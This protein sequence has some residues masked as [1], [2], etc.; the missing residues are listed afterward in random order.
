MWEFCE[1]GSTCSGYVGPACFVGSVGL[2]NCVPSTGGWVGASMADP[3]PPNTTQK[4][5]VP[6]RATAPLSSIDL[7]DEAGDG[8]W[9]LT[10][11][12]GTPRG[13]RV[14]SGGFSSDFQEPPFLDQNKISTVVYA[15]QFSA[16][17]LRPGS[18]FQIAFGSVNHGAIV[19]ING[20]EV[21]AHFGPMMPFNIDVTDAL[22]SAAPGQPVNLTVS[23][24][25]YHRLIGLV[26]SG[27]MY[28]EAW[29]N[30]TDGWQSRSC[31]GICR[32]VRLI[33][34]P[35]LRV[36]D[37]QTA[38]SVGPPAT[39]NVRV[40]I[41][42]DALTTSP[43]LSFT[44][45]LSS[46]NGAS[47][48]YPS[49]PPQSISRGVPPRSSVTVSFSVS[50]E[51]VGAESWW[52]PNRPYSP[53]YVA[54]LHFLNL[55]LSSGASSS[56][57]FGFVEHSARTFFWTL[58][59]ERVNHISD[60]TPEN[61]MSFYDAYAFS[62]SY[63]ATSPRD[64]WRQYMRVG[65]T[66]NRIHQSTPT[67][68]LLDAADEVGF[69]LK[70]ESPVRGGCD[71]T[72]CP[73]S[74]S[75]SGF[76]QS[77]TEL[78][79]SC[80]GHPSVFAYSVENESQERQGALLFIAALIDAANA[81]DPTVPLTTEGSSNS[82][83]YNGT[84]VSAVNLLHYAVPDDSRSYIRAVGECAWC[85]EKGLETFSSLAVAGR[86]NDV[87]YYS[88]W[89]WFNYWSNFIPGFNA[90]RHAWK[91]SG[92]EGRD[93]VDGVDG[94]G[95]PVISWVQR[96]FSPLLPMDH[97][98][99]LRNPVFTD[100]WPTNVDTV[101]A[102]NAVNRTVLVFNDVLRSDLRP[103]RPEASLRT[104][105]WSAC[106]DSAVTTPVAQGAQNVSVAPGF[107]ASAFV[108]FT[109]PPPGASARKLY[110]VLRNAPANSADDEDLVGVEDRVYILVAPASV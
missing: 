68:E 35:A 49:I 105:T 62:G 63:F 104:L 89:D 39:L 86:A 9:S 108:I 14:P 98:A 50:W 56:T 52:W 2:Q 25:P 3:L 12:G 19:S 96:A 43:P 83:F 92:C 110:V 94:F 4:F 40:T 48:A 79:V 90:S 65:I 11:D 82:Y 22:V 107:S 54:Q 60:A 81:A 73:S 71:Y 75:L 1:S 29:R 36:S 55:T 26:P 34:L 95:S 102:G 17:A 46:W 24:L 61:G 91:Q 37:V 45:S 6:S 8:A 109:A 47:F 74:F 59:G 103:W 97:S 21:G 80:R 42:N 7:S 85:V 72:A 84:N 16:P 10:V 5:A 70:P 20:V 27:F 106:W 87:A 67:E 13:I 69:L 18:I 51:G 28:A 88:G 100:G 23:V 33:E 41:L 31:A 99:F 64:V 58:N 76:T 77:M 57:R 101:F 32:F 30:D 78:A 44:G 53:T 93:R 38:S 15:R 66:S